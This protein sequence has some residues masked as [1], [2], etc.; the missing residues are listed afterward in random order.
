MGA[1]ADYAALLDDE[2][3]VG[4]DDGAH[5]LSDDDPRRSGGLLREGVAEVPVCP[6]VQCGE[7]VVEKVDRRVLADGS[8]YGEPLLL[9]SGKVPSVLGDVGVHAFRHPL[10]K[11]LQLR[12]ADRPPGLLVGLLASAV[13]DVVPHG[14][15]EDQGGLGNVSDHGAELPL[16]VVPDIPASDL[17]PAF[18]GVV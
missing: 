10:H 1:G 12:Y 11:L 2:D 5:P 4:V 7:G 17:H 6:G 13:A 9:T 15:G 3:L 16:G 8:R 18:G 14:P